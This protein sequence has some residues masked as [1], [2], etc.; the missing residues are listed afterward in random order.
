MMSPFRRVMGTPVHVESDDPPPPDDTPKDFRLS[1]L[2][3]EAERRQRHDADQCTRL[4][5][6]EQKLNNSNHLQWA[7][8]TLVTIEMA[9]VGAY[10]GWK[11]ATQQSSIVDAAAQRTESI[12]DSKLRQH[13]ESTRQSNLDTAREALRLEREDQVAR[14]NP[15]PIARATEVVASKPKPR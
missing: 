8:G 6:L 15:A 7:I 4:T 10:V 3:D 12:V 2:K 11:A 5:A 1:N 14:Q 9:L 13:L